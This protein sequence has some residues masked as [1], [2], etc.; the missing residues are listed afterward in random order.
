MGTGALKKRETFV[1]QT[2][3]TEQLTSMR[4]LEALSRSW[5]VSSKN[6]TGPSLSSIKAK[7]DD[8]LGW[9]CKAC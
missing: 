1:Q 5:S 7:N 2:R 6:G 3:Q 4:S 8:G 9:N